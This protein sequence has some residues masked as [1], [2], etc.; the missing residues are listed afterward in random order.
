MRAVILGCGRVGAAVAC[1]LAGRNDVTVIDWNAGSFR[2]LHDNF[3]GRTVVGNGIDVDCLRGAGAGKSDVF[4]ALTDG[5]NRNL[6]AAQ[7]AM[8]L[9]AKR[10]IARVYDAE[11]SEIFNDIGLPTISPTIIGAQRL[12]NLAVGNGEAEE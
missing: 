2:R 5:D 8:H 11:R 7:V 9:G 6:M 1:A 12:F 10:V 4:L 3:P